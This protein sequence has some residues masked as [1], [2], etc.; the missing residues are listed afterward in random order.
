MMADRGVSNIQLAT[1]L[2]VDPRVVS[3]WRKKGFMPERLNT[4]Y[5]DG[6]CKELNCTPNDL[7]LFEKEKDDA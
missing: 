3:R 5:L 7:L 2:N 4:Q 1:A 6:M